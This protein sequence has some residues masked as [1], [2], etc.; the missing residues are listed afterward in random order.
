MSMEQNNLFDF[1]ANDVAAGRKVK[2]LRWGVATA[3]LLIPAVFVIGHGFNPN[4]TWASSWTPWAML[5][6]FASAAAL[7]AGTLG[8]SAK[9]FG[10]SAFSGAVLA[11]AMVLPQFGAGF[12]PM[13]DQTGFWLDTLRC[14]GFGLM[15]GGLTSSVLIFSVFHLGPVPGSGTRLVM[16]QIAGLSGVVGLFFYCPNSDLVHLFAG[17]GLQTVAVFV[18]AFLLSEYL[19]ARIIHRQLGKAAGQFENMR[20]FDKG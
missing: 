7:V 12:A 14:F 8:R 13:V 16:S 3:A 9:V 18:A 2:L 5:L 6:S 17:H 19:F 20:K 4:L 11:L 1:I 15:M 10:L